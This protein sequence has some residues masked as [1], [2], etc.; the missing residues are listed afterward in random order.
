MLKL[1]G[2]STKAK[3]L[4][5]SAYLERKLEEAKHDVDAIE[6]AELGNKISRLTKMFGVSGELHRVLRVTHKII[7]LELNSKGPNT[8][9]F[10]LIAD[11]K[12]EADE[13][14]PILNAA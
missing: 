7:A 4:R 13:A 5:D 8:W 12:E 14:E 3:Y 6:V 1:V 10:L 11:S 2:A 9:G